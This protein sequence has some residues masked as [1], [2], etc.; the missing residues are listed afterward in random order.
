[1]NKIITANINGFIFPI[2]ELA[3]EK[4]KSYLLE[5]HKKIKDPETITDIENRIAELFSIQIQEGKVAIL[6]DDLNAVI[7]QIG[8]IS[9]IEEPENDH[10]TESK[11]KSNFT[12]I[13]SK[14]FFRDRENKQL[15]GVCSGLSAYFNLD[16]RLIRIIFILFIWFGVGI[17]LYFVI[18]LFTPYAN[19]ET[20]KAQMHGEPIDY[21]SINN[22]TKNNAK[23]TFNTFKNEVKNQH[24]SK[25]VKLLATFSLVALLSVIIPSIFG[26]IFSA[27][28]ISLV[29]ESFQRFILVDIQSIVLPLMATSFIVVIPVILI[30]YR[31][32]RIVFEGQKMP[33]AIKIVINSIWILSILY[34]FYFAVTLG[35]NFNSS[36]SITRTE[37]I[38][39]PAKD[40]ILNIKSSEFSI[41]KNNQEFVVEDPDLMDFMNNKFSENVS[42]KIF[43]TSE[44]L[45]YLKINQFSRGS[46]KNAINN[47]TGIHYPVTFEGNQLI[48][49]NYF[50][51]GENIPWRIQ[52][53]T[54]SLFVPE[55]Y[56]LIIDKSCSPIIH[57]V[58]NQDLRL[59]SD[60][61]ESVKLKSTSNGIIYLHP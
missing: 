19:S 40:S 52:E 36:Y 20:E 35:R 29:L 61:S 7:A 14:S 30:V 58:E 13:P 46:R 60:E 31:L 28:V 47:A 11:S 21:Q 50:T 27:G 5:L 17:L 57:E 22:T 54:V 44:K 24:N 25:T 49:S 34:M 33:K 4:L 59:D 15:F 16:V 55:G 18:T 10:H 38:K 26:L 53:V 12:S 32:I 8:E 2:D 45:P 3:Y 23:D 39:S 6:D 51:L 42:L 43:R 56:T 1:M 37:N 9:D 48:L 41:V